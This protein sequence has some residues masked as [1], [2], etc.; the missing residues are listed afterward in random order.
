MSVPAM[1]PAVDPWSAAE[2]R[3]EAALAI[4]RQVLAR[5]QD[6]SAPNE[7]VAVLRRELD[8][9]RLLGDA[10]SQLS[11]VQSASP[12]PFRDRLA[13]QLGELLKLEDQN[14]SLLTRRG[15]RLSYAR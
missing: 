3:C 4:S 7:L 13:S 11:K 14:H 5:L 10:V 1:S 9:V 15:L 2:E 6:D 8:Q 12:A